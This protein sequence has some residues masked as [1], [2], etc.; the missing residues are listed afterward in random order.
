MN[1]TLNWTSATNYN[2]KWPDPLPPA[3]A[4][5]ETPE[6]LQF[7]TQSSQLVRQWL[8][9]KLQEESAEVI[10]AVSKVRRFGEQNHHPD[11][12][13]TNHTELVDE[14]TDWLA[15]VAALEHL[16]YFDLQTEQTTI[17][18]KTRALIS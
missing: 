4:T 6:A 3:T 1:P 16:Q 18:K 10:Q 2:I 8:L 12:K 11:R 13:T 7:V 9:D 15:V 14:L 17:L 5:L